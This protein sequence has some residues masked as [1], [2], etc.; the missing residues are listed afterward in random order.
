MIF[1]NRWTRPRT[2]GMAIDE[3][4]FQ[5]QIAVPE[6]ECEGCLHVS[7]ATLSS[8]GSS[9]AEQG[10]TRPA[11]SQ[12]LKKRIAAAIGDGQ[13]VDVENRFNHAGFH[14]GIA[15][16]MHV[17]KMIDVIVVVITDPGFA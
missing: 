17:R 12:V 8:Q 6:S 14:Q 13:E 7:K 3:L 4:E 1:A 2:P 9:P 11:S 15:Y 16:V 5:G 10:I